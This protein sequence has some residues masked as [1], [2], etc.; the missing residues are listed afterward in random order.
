MAVATLATL[1]TCT[2]DDLRPQIKLAHELVRDGIDRSRIVF[3]LNNIASELD[4]L[5]V[6]EARSYIEDAGYHVTAQ[7]L[8]RQ[9]AYQNAQN[10]GLA[11]S[12]TPFATLRSVAERN[13]EEIYDILVNGAK[14]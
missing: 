5:A 9:Q 11:I 8:P 4:G 3:V 10:R 13:A 2:L 1:C 7:A 12:E 6:K 14:T